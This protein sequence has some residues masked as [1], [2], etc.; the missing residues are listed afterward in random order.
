MGA[1]GILSGVLALS[2]STVV[3]AQ[4]IDVP[5]TFAAFDRF[6]RPALQGIEALKDVVSVPGPNG[7]KVFAVSPD[8]HAISAQTSVDD[9]IIVA[10]FRYGAGFVLR[11]CLAQQIVATA[12]DYRSIDAAFQAAV[13]RGPEIT[14][15]GGEIVEEVPAVGAMRL[16]GAGNIARPRGVYMINGATEPDGSLV[17]AMTAQG[18]FTLTG[19]VRAAR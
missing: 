14:M 9:V 10:E 8:G 5:K 7:E 3:A 18:V 1:L 4:G 2:L 17:Q 16:A 11:N 12:D 13:W 15:T 19:F 6:C